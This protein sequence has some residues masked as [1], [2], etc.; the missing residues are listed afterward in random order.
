MYPECGVE[1]EVP[2]PIRIWSEEIDKLFFTCVLSS[3]EEVDMDEEI[4]NYPE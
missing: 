2:I 3:K 1:E 4:S